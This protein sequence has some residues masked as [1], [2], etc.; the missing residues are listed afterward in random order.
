M[1]LKNLL[2]SEAKW[3][4]RPVAAS[5]I[6][7]RCVGAFSRAVFRRD[8]TFAASPVAFHQHRDYLQEHPGG[9]SPHPLTLPTWLAVSGS[10]RRLASPSA[11]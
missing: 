7:T 11:G 10:P 2:A 3:T 1:T 8:G 4:R 5:R 9:A 6:G